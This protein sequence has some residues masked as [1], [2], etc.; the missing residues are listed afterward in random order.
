MEGYSASK[1][2]LGVPDPRD[3]RKNDPKWLRIAYGE[4]HV[5]ELKDPAENHRI[6]QYHKTCELLHE[7]FQ[8]IGRN[9]LVL[10]FYELVF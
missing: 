8:K 10:F 9:S 2:L 4:K 1:Y 7:D 5:A 3:I 6:I